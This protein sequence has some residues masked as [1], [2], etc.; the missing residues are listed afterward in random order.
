LIMRSVAVE[1]AAEDVVPVSES[2]SQAASDCL[3]PI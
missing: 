2:S 3:S 1:V